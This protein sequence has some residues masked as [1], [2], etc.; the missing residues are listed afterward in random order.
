MYIAFYSQISIKYSTNVNNI[1]SAQYSKVC[2]QSTPDSRVLVGVIPTG[3]V[4]N[5]PLDFVPSY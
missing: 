5:I 4:E 2:L 3:Y 1:F